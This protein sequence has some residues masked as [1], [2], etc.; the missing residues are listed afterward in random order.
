MALPDQTLE[1]TNITQ[2]PRL[3]TLEGVELHPVANNENEKLPK[4]ITTES[5]GDYVLGKYVY[6][7]TLY[8][9]ANLNANTTLMLTD[10]G[11]TYLTTIGD[12]SGAITP[13]IIITGTGL[14]YVTNNAPNDKNIDV[15]K[16]TIA[17]CDAAVRDDVAV[18]PLGLSNYKA[19]IAALEAQMAD[20][21]YKPMAI[22]M[23]SASPNTV[24][25]GSSVGSVVLS[26]ALNKT[27]T[28]LS[29][30]GYVGPAILPS[31]T[32]AT[33]N[34]PF[35]TDKTWTLS[36][37]DGSGRPGAGAT[38]ST[39][40]VFRNKRYW[41]VSPNTTLTGPEII[42]LSSEFSTSRVKD[43]TYNASGG[44][45]SNYIYYAYP[46]SF[47]NLNAVTVGGLA[48]SDYTTTVVNFT[49]ASGYTSQ[50][51]LIRINNIQTGAN[52]AVHWA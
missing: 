18:T 37:N 6:N 16:A 19:R 17:E 39:S 38:A 13:N 27:A 14:A 12:L 52:I 35:S 20:L 47:G 28:T 49:N 9:A 3:D 36:V 25:I 31:D 23:F 7:L 48:F 51:N 11:Q 4:S 22:T 29:M 33:A 42:A 21:L 30:T 26:W 32:T 34:G 2:M 41:G 50:Y 46:T 43:I 1:L 15:P 24:E 8:P 45:G 10:T 44:T 5:I 40:L